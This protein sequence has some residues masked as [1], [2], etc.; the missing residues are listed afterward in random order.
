MEHGPSALELL[1][2]N[3]AARHALVIGT[4]C[5]EILKPRCRE[6]GAGQEADLVVV[7]PSRAER[8]ERNWLRNA[9]EA[10]E[11]ALAPDGVVYVVSSPL[12]RAR[13]ARRLAARDLEVKLAFAH[14][15]STP[16]VRSLVPLSSSAASYAFTNLIATRPGRRRLVLFALRARWFARLLSVTLPNAGLAA[17][18]RSSRPLFEWLFASS[19]R[20]VMDSTA[21]VSVGTRGFAGSVVA[22]GFADGLATPVVVAK[23]GS[24]GAARPAREA[25]ILE[26][27]GPGARA[28]G[29]ALPEVMLVECDE[30]RAVLFETPVPG[31]LAAALLGDTPA[32]LPSLTQRLAE[33]LESWNLETRTE[34]LLSGTWLEQEVGGPARVLAPALADGGRYLEW[35]ES[36][37]SAIAGTTVPLVA[38]HNDLTMVNVFVARSDSLGVVDW[39]SAR[40]QGLPLVDLYYAAADAAAAADRYADRAASFAG[41][42]G[43]GPPAATRGPERR[44]V[45]ALGLPPTIVELAFHACWL[46]HAAAEQRAG[47]E[48]GPRPFLEIL[49]RVAETTS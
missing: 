17:G 12:G 14:D 22:H 47:P 15:P 38:T 31:R 35:L 49:R 13:I 3:G 45:E 43:E 46:Q 4:C 2:P 36:R 32:L 16:G 33:W 1:H 26:A 25:A 5:P 19:E 27:L 7:A 18:R 24:P 8:R 44:I 39:E 30:R 10:A 20:P 48:S 21:V 37:C 9:V 34:Q 42:F 11:A 29:A 41:L 23:V 28:A 6:P 40:E